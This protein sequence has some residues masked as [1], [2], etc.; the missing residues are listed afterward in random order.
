MSRAY[1]YAPV[2]RPFFI[3]I[4]DEDWEDGDEGLV[5][6]LQ[7][8]LYGTRDAAQNSAA[9]VHQVLGEDRVPEEQSVQLQLR[10]QEEED[11]NDSAWR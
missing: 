10:A 6:H 1:F 11:Q 4:P 9:M 7:V 3:N 2:T 8:S 5:G